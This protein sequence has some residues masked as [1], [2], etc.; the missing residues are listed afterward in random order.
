MSHVLLHSTTAKCIFPRVKQFCAVLCTE[1]LQENR[2]SGEEEKEEEQK[3]KKAAADKQQEGWGVNDD[4]WRTERDS[5]TEVR[6]QERC[7]DRRVRTGT[8]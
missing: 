2:G 7:S 5:E 4:S 3:K 6:G 1:W 8:Q